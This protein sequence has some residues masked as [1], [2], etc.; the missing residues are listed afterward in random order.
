M[1]TFDKSSGFET[2]R[3][4]VSW[5]D[6]LRLTGPILNVEIGV[7]AG[8][9]NILKTLGVEIPVP[10]VGPALIDT[11]AGVCVIDESA[12]RQLHLQ[13][14]GTVPVVGVSAL[15]QRPTYAVRFAFPELGLW[16]EPELATSSDHLLQKQGIVA[17][18]GRDLLQHT[19]LIY[20]GRL[21][22]ITIAW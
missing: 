5:K 7:P 10:A 8:A 14:V 12:A 20:N 17:L 18:I 21:G 1:A 3:G 19:V 6:G 16:F 22:A 11:G 4:R 13:P 2:P 9:A 15:E